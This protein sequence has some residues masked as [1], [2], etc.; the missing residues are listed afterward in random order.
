MRHCLS[1]FVHVVEKCHFTKADSVNGTWQRQPVVP[2][3]RCLHRP[4]TIVSWFDLARSLCG[5]IQQRW[6]PACRENPHQM[7]SY[8]NKKHLRFTGEAQY[9]YYVDRKQCPTAKNKLCTVKIIVIFKC[10]MWSPS[11]QLFRSNRHSKQHFVNNFQHQRPCPW[12]TA[13]TQVG[14]FFFFFFLFFFF[15]HFFF[16]FDVPPLA[17][18]MTVGIMRALAAANTSKLSA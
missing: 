6:L 2:H 7:I 11:Q 4:Q 13:R 3:D 10:W 18:S 16:F 8:V 17:P 14:G 1:Y 5:I 12:L 9:S 15:F